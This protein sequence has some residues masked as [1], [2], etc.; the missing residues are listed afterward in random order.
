MCHADD[1]GSAPS[2]HFS[3]THTPLQWDSYSLVPQSELVFLSYLH[4][5]SR[6]EPIVL[7]P[8]RHKANPSQ[9][10]LCVSFPGQS[11]TF[12]SSILGLFIYFCPSRLVRATNPLPALQPLLTSYF[13]ALNVASARAELESE[14]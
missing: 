2:I 6:S 1:H 14:I 9:Q 4:A 3:Q 7:R 12:F 10:S 5:L 8:G 11:L 13:K